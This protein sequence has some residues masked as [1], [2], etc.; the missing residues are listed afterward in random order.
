MS[1][2]SDN[3]GMLRMSGKSVQKIPFSGQK[4]MPLKGQKQTTEYSPMDAG[5]LTNSKITEVKNTTI[6][7]NTDILIITNVKE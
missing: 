4:K 7:K 2:K 6:D 1:E 5:T 3:I